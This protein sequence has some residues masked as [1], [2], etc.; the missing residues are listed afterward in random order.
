MA[1]RLVFRNSEGR[2]LTTGDLQR[3]TGRV[4][5]EIVGDEDVP[6]EAHPETLGVLLINKAG[7]LARRGDR[8]AAVA[9]L[10]ELALSPESTLGTEHLAK[11]ALAGLVA[12]S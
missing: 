12:G 10:G 8:D 11:F 6:A 4:R 9:I 7:I 2:E 5:W 1:D 3:C